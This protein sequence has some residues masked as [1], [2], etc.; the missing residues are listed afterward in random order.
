[1]NGALIT[2]RKD[3]ATGLNY[4][5]Y[6]I[7][8]KGMLWIATFDIDHGLVVQVQEATLSEDRVPEHVRKAVQDWLL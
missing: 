7:K 1:M 8:H 2:V 6:L 5:V 4:G 3:E